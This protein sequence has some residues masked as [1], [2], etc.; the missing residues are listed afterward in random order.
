MQRFATWSLHRRRRVIRPYTATWRLQ[1][2]RPKT[3]ESGP[4]PKAQESSST[5][6]IQSVE[7]CT[8]SNCMVPNA[9]QRLFIFISPRWCTEIV[10]YRHISILEIR[11]LNFEGWEFYEYFG[12]LS[13]VYE[14]FSILILAILHLRKT[15]L[16]EG[17]GYDERL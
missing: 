5:F 1:L 12:N 2:E 10:E 11:I 3:R 13:N 15:Y 17:R 14:S 4:P 16:I 9:L 7:M 6:V 8:C